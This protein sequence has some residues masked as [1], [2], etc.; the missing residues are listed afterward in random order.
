MS[1]SAGTWIPSTNPC[2]KYGLI[3]LPLVPSS[4]GPAPGI[5]RDH[6]GVGSFR[7]RW[8]RPQRGE[9]AQH[10]ETEAVRARNT[11]AETRETWGTDARSQSATTL[12][13]TQLTIQAPRW[14]E[15][16]RVAAQPRLQGDA[17]Y[18]H[19]VRWARENDN[20]CWNCGLGWRKNRRGWHRGTREQAG[21]RSVGEEHVGISQWTCISSWEPCIRSSC[22]KFRYQHGFT[23]YFRWENLFYNTCH[24]ESM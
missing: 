5:R 18:G 9:N 4:L 16:L 1:A 15:N 14:R 3:I 23:A 6:L 8:R 12:F 22:F 20:R 19:E 10:D 11:R 13:P 17:Q 21:A 2:Y 24:L 7:R